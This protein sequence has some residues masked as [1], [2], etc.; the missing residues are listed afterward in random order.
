MTISPSLAISVT[1]LTKNSS[2]KLRATLESTKDF[3]EVVVL[4][5]GSTDNT[6]EIARSF[7]NVKFFESEFLGFG[8]MKKKAASLATHDWIFNLDSDEV[9]SPELLLALKNLK[10]APET[11]YGF[12]RHNHYRGK[13]IKG[14]DWYPDRVTRLYNKKETDYNDAKLHEKI[15]S[16]PSQKLIYVDHPIQHFPYENVS[17]LIQKLDHY[18]SIY[19]S[20]KK[21]KHISLLGL[22]LRAAYSFFRNYILKRGFLLGRDGLLISFCSAAGVFFKNMKLLEANDES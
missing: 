8:P 10:L 11:V 4:D 9:L 15:G 3:Q 21:G 5:S 2:K 22:S 16:F 20:E 14:C 18:S 7:S 1:V 6:Q 19:A 12:D 17:S 13:W